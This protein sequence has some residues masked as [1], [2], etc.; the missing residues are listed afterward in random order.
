MTTIRAPTDFIF[1]KSLAIVSAEGQLCLIVCC[2]VNLDFNMQII[3]LTLREYTNPPNPYKLS[4]TLI[5]APEDVDVEPA[6]DVVFCAGT[7]AL[8]VC[9]VSGFGAT[10][11][12]CGAVVD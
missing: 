7:A 9:V 12:A 6:C 8:A 3:M 10:V 2:S 4:I 5:R 11:E 1:E